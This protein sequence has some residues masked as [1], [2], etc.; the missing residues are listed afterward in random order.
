VF[1]PQTTIPEDLLL[2]C[3]DPE[4]DAVKQ[5]QTFRFALAGGVVAE[6]LAAGALALDGHRLV[7]PPDASPTGP[8]TA[9]PSHPPLSHPALDQSL[10]TLTAAM[11]RTG[12]G[13]RSG[14][15]RLSAHAARPYLDSLA[16][17]GLLRPER[18]RVLGLFPATRH[19]PLHT[20]VRAERLALLDD[21]LRPDPPT[22]D[23]APRARSLRLAALASAG[24]LDRRLFP[25]PEGRQSRRRQRE[26]CA[27]D[28]LA[29][30]VDQTI[31]AARSSAAGG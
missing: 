31:S 3:V 12:L 6:L 9:P 4:S 13:L 16:E 27:E 8:A 24:G 11:G 25:G 26:L 14:L 28:P 18:T 10:A 22:T 30:A 21:A 15:H 2:L 19:R 17:R 20:G 29:H 7:H 5:P 23:P 1:G